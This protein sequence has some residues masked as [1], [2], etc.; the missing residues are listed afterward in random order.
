[1]STGWRIRW[2]KAEKA[3]CHFK[4]RQALF[5]VGVDASHGR[6]E[7][8]GVMDS[9]KASFLWLLAGQFNAGKPLREAILA[10]ESRMTDLGLERLNADTT[11]AETA[12][13]PLSGPPRIETACEGEDERRT[14]RDD[15]GG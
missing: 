9:A 15:R 4:A 2:T 3:R 6:F 8:S 10:A 13:P 5:A 7:N 11:P 12:P 1:M 14:G